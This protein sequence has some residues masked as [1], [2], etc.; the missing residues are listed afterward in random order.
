MKLYD[1]GKI[2]A[3]LVLFVVLAVSPFLYNM[4]VGESA[5]RPELELP[6]KSVHP[7]CVAPVEQMRASHMDL[8]NDWRDR[9]V[10]DGDRI[11]TAPDG[12]EYEMSLS[13]TCL[14]CHANK[15]KFCDRC[16]GYLDVS[17]YC[18]DCHNLPGGK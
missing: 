17:P 15:E 12:T 3:G 13:N 9:V 7:N 4:T 11:Y 2:T 10:R 1:G 5:A 16:H 8:L 6:D 14:D 18:W